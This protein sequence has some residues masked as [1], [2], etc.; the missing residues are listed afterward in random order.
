VAGRTFGP[1]KPN[2]KRSLL[3]QVEKEDLRKSWLTRVHLEKWP[4][5]ASSSSSLNSSSSK[6]YILL[7]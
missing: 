4:L 2:P 3:E 5:N 6:T 1:Q 7:F